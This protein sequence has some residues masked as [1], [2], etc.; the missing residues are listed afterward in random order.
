[1]DAEITDIIVFT[2]FGTS[3]LVVI[4]KLAPGA[5]DSHHFFAARKAQFGWEGFATALAFTLK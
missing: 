3:I 2:S 1:M 4:G 5:A